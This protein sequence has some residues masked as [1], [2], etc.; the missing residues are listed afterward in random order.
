MEI[1]TSTQSQLI[2]HAHVEFQYQRGMQSLRN[3][4]ELS[5]E[6]VLDKMFDYYGG[7][8]DAFMVVDS[9]KVALDLKSDSE[10]PADVIYLEFIDKMKNLIKKNSPMYLEFIPDV[11]DWNV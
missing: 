9:L 1:I 6:K 4:N 7:Y 11:I 10:D 8:D 5:L 3:S 2:H